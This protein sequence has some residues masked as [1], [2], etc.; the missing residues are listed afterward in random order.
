M[1][2]FNEI[3][4][5]S[6]NENQI[7]DFRSIQNLIYYRTLKQFDIAEN[8][9]ATE[10]GIDIKKEMIMKFTLTTNPYLRKINDDEVTEDD[11]KDC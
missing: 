6:L 2:S 8:P 9:V 1:G 7:P 4:H 10:G 3:L 5:L 11:L